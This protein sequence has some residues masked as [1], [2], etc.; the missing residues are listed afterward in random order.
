MKD[1]RIRSKIGFQS[2]K[3]AT[4]FP[5]P[6]PWLGGGVV[7]ATWGVGGGVGVAPPYFG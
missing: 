7:K 4:S 5:G 3:T 2:F 6:L 1:G